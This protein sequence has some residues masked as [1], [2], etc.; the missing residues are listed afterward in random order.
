MLF[1]IDAR[2]DYGNAFRLEEL[3]L[4]GCV[5]FANEDFTVGAEDAVPRNAFAAR[6]SAHGAPRGTGAAPETQ[7]SREAPIG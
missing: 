4:K 6:S 7:G 5:G 3:F 2:F 1:Q